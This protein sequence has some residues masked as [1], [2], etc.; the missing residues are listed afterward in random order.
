MANNN[1]GCNK[2]TGASKTP[3]DLTIACGT[4]LVTEKDI[5]FILSH[6][7][8]FNLE[9][10]NDAEN[11]RLQVPPHLRRNGVW[12][13]YTDN[14]GK[15]ITERYIGTDMQAQV[16][17]TWK[18]EQYWEK[19]DFEEILE[20]A[21]NAFLKILLNLDKYPKFQDFLAKI[22]A[23]LFNQHI[24]FD[25]IKDLIE[26]HLEAVLEKLIPQGYLRSIILQIAERLIND[27]I[28]SNAFKDNIKS[29]ILEVLGD[30]IEDFIESVIEDLINAYFNSGCGEDLVRRIIE[31]LLKRV[32]EDYFSDIQQALWDEERV[33]ANALA[34]HEMAITE[35]QNQVITD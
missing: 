5:E 34:R 16:S 10:K 25:D 31:D 24:D 8:F 19:L 18:D 7:N 17:E 29:V 26:P 14:T 32:V 30:S 20:S 12:V 9:W 22:L 33:I 6:Y 4:E 27:F 11:T 23:D 1:C 3:I 21:E 35:L 15:R 28:H 13:T 2:S